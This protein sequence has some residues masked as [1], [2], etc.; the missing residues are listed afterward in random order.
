VDKDKEAEIHEEVRK[1]KRKLTGCT[2]CYAFVVKID[3]TEGWL[4]LYVENW[5]PTSKSIREAVLEEGYTCEVVKIDRVVIPPFIGDKVV[6][7]MVRI[8]PG[9]Y[10]PAVLFPEDTVGV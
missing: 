1:I 9:E 4:R 8:E 2:E 6:I 7:K 3:G 10:R 5:L